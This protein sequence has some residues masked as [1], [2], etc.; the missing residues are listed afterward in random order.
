MRGHITSQ[1]MHLASDGA[2]EPDALLEISRHLE[3]CA[4]CARRAG[5][6]VDVDALAVAVQDAISA[7][8]H[9][10]MSELTGYAE[11]DLDATAREWVE[12]HLESCVWCR[13]DLA[14]LRAEQ[15][16][17]GGRWRAWQWI[18]AAVL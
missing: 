15:E 17:L 16:S 4:L 5:E 12:A 18:A 10:E 2:I 1:E 11:D 9:P 8:E 13:E 6:L 14:D 3:V 7:D